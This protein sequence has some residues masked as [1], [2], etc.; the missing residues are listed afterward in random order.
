MQQILSK[1]SQVVIFKSLYNS[2]VLDPESIKKVNAD[3]EDIDNRIP[4]LSRLCISD[5][6]HLKAEYLRIRNRILE[7]ERKSSV[8]N[9]SKEIKKGL[10]GIG[11]ELK[12][13]IIELNE[14]CAM[15]LPNIIII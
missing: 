8:Q 4:Y 10:E 11:L 2:S 13:E 7:L 5:A 3:L 6:N 9:T 15:F 14:M 1:L 12:Q